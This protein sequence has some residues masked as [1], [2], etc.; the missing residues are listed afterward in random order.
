MAEPSIDEL[1]EFE[2]NRL[3]SKQPGDVLERLQRGAEIAI[4]EAGPTASLTALGGSLGGPPGALAGLAAGTLALPVADLAVGAYNALT[5]GDVQAPSAAYQQFMTEQLGLAKPETRGERIGS[6]AGRALLEA[7]V[8]ARLATSAAKALPEA[9]STARN[10]LQTA[11]QAPVTQGVSS[12][13]AATTAQGLSEAGASPYV[14]VPLSVAAGTVP[15]VRPNILPRAGGPIR[16]QNVQT[17]EAENI[18]LSPAQSQGSAPAQVLESVMKYLPTSAARVAA[19]EDRTQRAFTRNVLARAG[20]DSDIAT[21]EVLEQAAENFGKR[22]DFLES[23]MVIRPDDILKSDIDAVTSRYIKQ[24]LPTNVRGEF[25]SKR[26]RIIDFIEKGKEASG[27]SYR[28]LKSEL[29]EDIQKAAR[30][31]SP[32]SGRYKR[33]LEGLQTALEDAM[34]RSSPAGLAQQ[35]KDLDKQFAIFSRIKDTMKRAGEEKLNTGFI[36]AKQLASVL[37]GKDPDRWVTGT[38]DFTRFARAG[39]AVLPNPI[40]NSGTAQRS[41]TQDLITGGRRGAPALGAGAATQTLGYSV[42]DP[43]SA[44]LGPYAVSRAWY[45][46]PVSQELLGI[47]GARSLSETQRTQ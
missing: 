38:D 36:P 19:V 18:P 3:M 2:R 23:Q 5:D 28:G 39:A 14:S 26:N 6:S 43:I 17:L 7:A 13:L 12:A 35:A 27:E 30:D 22:Y 11:G 40:P 25:K 46:R 32:S 29:S 8:P 4:R 1:I 45:G 20:I 47:L 15:Y 37:T 9:Y 10:V 33:A 44:L 42:I 34:Q 16:Q 21:P 41:F 24:D 31:T